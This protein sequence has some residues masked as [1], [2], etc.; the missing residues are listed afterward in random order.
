MVQRGTRITTATDADY[1]VTTEDINRIIRVEAYY[2]VD[3]GR[4][5]SARL[6]ADYLVLAERSSN[7]AP[8]FSPTAV[9]REVNEGKKGMNVGAPVTATDDITNKLTYAIATV[10]DEATSLD[11]ARFKIDAK[12]G[13][14]TTN[15]DL[16][17]EG[18]NPADANTLG[19]CSGADGTDADP[20]CTVVVTATDSAGTPAG[21]PATVTIKITNVDEK[22]KFTSGFKMRDVAEGTTQVDNNDDAT[23]AL[24]GDAIYTATDEDGLNVNLSLMGSD[25]PKFQL[26]AVETGET[27]SFRMKPNYEMPT[28]ANKDNVY[29][30]TVRATDGTMYADRMVKVTVIGVDEAPEIIQGGF[31]SVSGRASVSYAENDTADVATYTAAGSDAASAGGR[32]KAT[33][34][35]TSGS[36]VPRA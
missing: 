23:D 1:T 32:W 21:T 19:S 11:A 35:A 12:T 5:E 6:T 7:E 24:E 4:E 28:D 8:E 15:V 3:D 20:E 10:S 33:T 30:V 31:L 26:S 9:T 13:Q 14:I 36:A 22:P 29:E 16:D 18:V 17:R 27:L 2:T 25:A 34:R